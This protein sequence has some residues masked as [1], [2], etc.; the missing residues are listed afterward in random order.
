M[1]R[2]GGGYR[3]QTR[4]RDIDGLGHVN[5]AVALTYLEEG[6]DRFL[7]GH[8]I[9]RDEYVVGSCSLRFSDE[10]DPDQETVMVECE[11]REVGRSSLAT[12]ERIIRDDGNVVV[13][14]EFGIVLWDSE[15]R[16]SRPLSDGE[17]A[18]LDGQV[19]ER[20]AEQR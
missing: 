9:S 1:T 5:H 11:V 17:R 2:L 15:R 20:R 8:G 6:R 16:A 4:W 18:S 3:V 7:A 13:E 19:A 10:M 12:S 14:A